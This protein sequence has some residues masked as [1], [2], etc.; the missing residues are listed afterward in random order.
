MGGSKRGLPRVGMMAMLGRVGGCPHDEAVPA[1]GV[2]PCPGV[3]TLAASGGCWGSATGTAAESLCPPA[4]SPRHCWHG[5]AESSPASC[6][7]HCPWVRWDRS[8]GLP[9][10]ACAW[11]GRGWG[12]PPVPQLPRTPLLQAAKALC[13]C[14]GPPSPFLGADRQEGAAAALGL[15]AGCPV[16]QDGSPQPQ[17]PH[18]AVPLCSPPSRRQ[19][20]ASPGCPTPDG[21]R[22][23]A[24]VP[25]LPGKHSPTS[26]GE[27]PPG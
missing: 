20:G 13:L 22:A 10:P 2:K 15:G 11:L 6:P 19:A 4:W 16:G 25:C 26:G 21:R 14:P 1:P 17:P 8:W 23:H 3:L 9:C 5:W 27:L 7:R 24:C 18:A 12:S